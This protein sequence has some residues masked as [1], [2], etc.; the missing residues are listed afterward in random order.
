MERR[1]TSMF[2]TMP[3]KVMEML[4]QTVRLFKESG[5]KVMGKFIA[6]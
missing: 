1:K 4:T 6:S 5:A 3:S 2:S